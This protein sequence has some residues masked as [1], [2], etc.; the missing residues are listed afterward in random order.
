MDRQQV[1]SLAPIWNVGAPIA[2]F[3]AWA[4]VVERPGYSEHTRAAGP[5]L[6]G[7]AYALTGTT[8]VRPSVIRFLTH[9]TPEQFMPWIERAVGLHLDAVNTV[10]LLNRA[11]RE[12][13]V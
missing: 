11:Y 7:F 13:H 2:H 8:P 12:D 10:A 3:L 5:V 4:D 6:R 9:A 1:L